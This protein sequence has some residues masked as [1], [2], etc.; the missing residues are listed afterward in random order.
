MVLVTTD[1][2]RGQS[3][4]VYVPPGERSMVHHSY[5]SPDGR[6]VL[7]V[8]MDNRGELGPCQVVPFDGSGGARVVGPSQAT[9]TFWRLVTRRQMGL[10]QFKSRRPVS[11]LA[12]EI[13]RRTAQQVTSGTT[14]EEGIAMSPDGKSL[15]TS[16]GVR[17]NTVWIHDA[18]GD[19]QLSSEG[20]ASGL[21]SPGTETS[22]IT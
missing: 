17:D 7:L 16:V 6:W 8:A 20:I 4:D 15:L 13:S 19:R 3:R 18:G 10:R 9:C 22:S 21:A 14:E 12:A 5:L 1:E 2:A 11:H